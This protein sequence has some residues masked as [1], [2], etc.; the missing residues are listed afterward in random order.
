MGCELERQSR[1]GRD[2][3]ALSAHVCE[4]GL[5]PF[6]YFGLQP[7]IGVENRKKP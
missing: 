7:G 2:L 5:S 4:K 6:L 1:F 3:M